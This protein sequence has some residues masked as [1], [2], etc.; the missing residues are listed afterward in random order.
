[1]VIKPIPE[2]RK[3]DQSMVIRNYM[4]VK[5]D[6]LDIVEFEME[7]IMDDPALQHLLLKNDNQVL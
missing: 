2:I 7:K 5:Q 1:M 4:Q 3:I 6:V